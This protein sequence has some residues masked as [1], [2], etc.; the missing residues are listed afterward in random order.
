MPRAIGLSSDNNGLVAQKRHQDYSGGRR[1][2][3]D[4]HH[5]RRQRFLTA[6]ISLI[7]SDGELTAEGSFQIKVTLRRST[8]PA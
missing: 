7:A 5:T 6:L 2:D 4:Y 8:T 3:E 1:A